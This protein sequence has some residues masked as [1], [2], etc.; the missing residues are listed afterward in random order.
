MCDAR[1]YVTIFAISLLLAASLPAGQP[2]G[3]DFVLLRSTVDGGGG[4]SSGEGFILTGTVGQPDAGTQT[5]SGG[6]YALA[7]G[8]WA[9]IGNLVVELI[10]GDGFE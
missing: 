9:Q 8:F 2:A 7:G 4:S 1:S 6:E 10:F 3:G 5:A